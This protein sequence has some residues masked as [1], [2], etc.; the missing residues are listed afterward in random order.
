VTPCT[1]YFGSYGNGA[2]GGY[3][4]CFCS[5][6]LVCFRRLLRALQCCIL[7][8]CFCFGLVQTHSA[9]IDLYLEYARNQ[10]E[11]LISGGSIAGGFSGGGDSGAAASVYS[12]S[13]NS[14]KQ[15]PSLEKASTI[16]RRY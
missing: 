2:R 14:L 8:G 9:A 12:F 1:G 7:T 10:I 15:S 16:F 4:L 3:L 13:Y 5:I 6:S 11:T